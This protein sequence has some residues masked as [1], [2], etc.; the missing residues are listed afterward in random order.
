MGCLSVVANI[1][2]LVFGGM[3][4]AI[5][6]LVLRRDLHDPDRDHP[7]RQAVPEAG[8]ALADALRAPRRARPGVEPG[9]SVLGDLLWIVFCGLWTGLGFVFVGIVCCITII[10]IPFGIQA[11]KLAGLAFFPFGKRVV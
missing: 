7:F 5:G 3:W 9:I 8:Q 4:L 10:G 1:I 11:F 6:F 2:W